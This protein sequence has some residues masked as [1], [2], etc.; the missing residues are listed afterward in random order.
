MER[1]REEGREAKK[2]GNTRG[3]KGTKKK[4]KDIERKEERK[5]GS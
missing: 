4:R 2:D 5:E 3:M 1:R